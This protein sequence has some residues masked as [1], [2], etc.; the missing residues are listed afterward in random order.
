MKLKMSGKKSW[1][2]IMLI[3]VAAALLLSSC[4]GIAPAAG[5]SAAVPTSALQ[6]AFPMS[7]DDF[8][9]TYHFQPG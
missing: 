8:V 2:Y 7:V 6:P 5:H 4:G 3:G 9:K 1:S